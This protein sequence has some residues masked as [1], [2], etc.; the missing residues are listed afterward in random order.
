M[1]VEIWGPQLT[2]PLPNNCLFNPY[3]DFSDAILHPHCNYLEIIEK[4]ILKSRK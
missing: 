3:I 4:E 1:V 2:V